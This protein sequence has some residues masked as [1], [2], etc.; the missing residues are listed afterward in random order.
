[1]K[2]PTDP[3]TIPDLRPRADP[4]AYEAEP[5]R[6]ERVRA[7][8][9]STPATLLALIV[10]SSPSRWRGCREQIRAF[11]EV[12]LTCGP[13][14]AGN[15]IGTYVG[16]QCEPASALIRRSTISPRLPLPAE[17]RCTPRPV[18]AAPGLA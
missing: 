3:T 16:T 17:K 2:G 9:A 15:T 5:H 10:P 6:P 11:A 14:L 4:I 18:A 7:Q 12:I 8:L 13:P 1:M